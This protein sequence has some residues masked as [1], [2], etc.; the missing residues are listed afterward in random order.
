[1]IHVA[2]D[3]ANIGSFSEEEVR[4]GLRTGRFLPTDMAWQEGIPDWRPLAQVVADKPVAAM[5]APDPAGANALPSSGASGGGLAWEH[6]E[7]VARK[8]KRIRSPKYVFN[9]AIIG[10]NSR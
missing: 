6:R 10:P 5:P 7:E 4:E 3:G 2:R 9:S 8:R 1:M